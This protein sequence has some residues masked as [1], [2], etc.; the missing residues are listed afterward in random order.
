MD[1]G[2]VGLKTVNECERFIIRKLN[3]NL[4]TTKKKFIE[5]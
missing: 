3:F 5:K 4:T 1:I 2:G